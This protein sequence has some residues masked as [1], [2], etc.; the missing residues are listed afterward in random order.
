MN[1]LAFET[2]QVTY[3]IVV[4]YISPSTACPILILDMIMVSASAEILEP[5][6]AR[7]SAY[8]VKLEIRHICSQVHSP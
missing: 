5:N 6:N 8:T 4:N 7:P 2:E 3:L 1:Y